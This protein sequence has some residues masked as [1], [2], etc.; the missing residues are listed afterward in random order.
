MVLCAMTALLGGDATASPI[1]GVHENLKTLG[2][3][4]DLSIEQLEL[5]D[6]RSD[7]GWHL[8]WFKTDPQDVSLDTL[9]VEDSLTNAL[10]PDGGT[11][12]IGLIPAIDVTHANG[13]GVQGLNTTDAVT[14]QLAVVPEPTSLILLGSGIAALVAKAR[15]RRNDKPIA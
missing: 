12:G 14:G 13:S 4:H 11:N 15:N 10:F 8:G 2:S 7:S 1:L 9:T 3:T 5:L 6:S